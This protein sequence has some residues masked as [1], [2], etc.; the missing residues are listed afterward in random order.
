MVAWLHQVACLVLLQHP[1]RVASLVRPLQPLSQAVSLVAAPPR[2]LVPR[3]LRPLVAE[4][5]AACLERLPALL[6]PL[7]ALVAASLEERLPQRLRLAASLA[8]QLRHLQQAACLALP[9]QQRPSVAASLAPLLR[10]VAASLV[11]QQQ[12]QLAACLA[13]LLHPPAA[14]L[15]L[16]QQQAVSLA[17]Q[18]RRPQAAYLALPLRR[19][20]SL[21]PAPPPLAPPSLALLPALAGWGAVHLQLQRQWFA[22]YVVPYLTLC[23]FAAAAM[24]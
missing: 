16:P 24:Q 7:L 23:C 2:P 21:A 13:P 18:H 1:H 20:A 5:L 15:G 14:C 22:R 11:P 10:Q 19:A 12:P 8:R 6:L 9:Q 4:P 3:R 17:P